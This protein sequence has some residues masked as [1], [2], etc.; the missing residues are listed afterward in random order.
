MRKI[1]CI[2]AVLTLILSMAACAKEAPAEVT[3]L[4]STVPPETTEETTEAT[5]EETTEETTEPAPTEPET[6]SAMAKVAYGELRFGTLERGTAVTVI[7]TFGDY[8]VIE[9]AEADLLIEQRFLRAEDDKPLLAVLPGHAGF[10]IGNHFLRK[11][12]I[13][14]TQAEVYIRHRILIEDQRNNLFPVEPDAIAVN[15]GLIHPVGAQGVLHEGRRHAVAPVPFIDFRHEL[16]DRHVV[17]Q[18]PV[19]TMGDVHYILL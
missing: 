11:A 13:T 6:V 5:T 15:I 4:P 17:G 9:G 3:V 8:C 10:G 12:F 7:G 14:R 16:V 1:I 2:L 19:L 18:K